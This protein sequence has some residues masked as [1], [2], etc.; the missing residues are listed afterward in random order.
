MVSKSDGYFL[1]VCTALPLHL[2]VRKSLQMTSM[3]RYIAL[4]KKNESCMLLSLIIVNIEL[5]LILF[6]IFYLVDAAAA[7]NNARISPENNIDFYAYSQ[8]APYSVIFAIFIFIY[9]LI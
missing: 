6:I 2:S 1:C 4:S 8:A 5:S 9:F 7:D 3:N